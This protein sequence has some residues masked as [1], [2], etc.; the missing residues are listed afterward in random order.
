MS[1]FNLGRYRTKEEVIRAILA[2]P[3][4]NSPGN[5]I[6]GAMHALRTY[7]LTSG[8]RPLVQKVALTFVDQ[9]ASDRRVLQD[10]LQVHN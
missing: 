4:I 7:A 5:D 1:H 6:A 10:A 9:R 8:G 2:L 3:T